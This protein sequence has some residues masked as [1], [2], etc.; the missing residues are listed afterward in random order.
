MLTSIFF[1]FEYLL[2][3]G[4][5]WHVALSNIIDN[6]ILDWE[7]NRQWNYRDALYWIFA[8]IH[9][10][11][12]FQLTPALFP[13]YHRKHQVFPDVKLTLCYASF[14]CNNRLTVADKY[15]FLRFYGLELH[16][17]TMSFRQKHSFFAPAAIFHVKPSS[18]DTDDMLCFNYREL[19][20]TLGCKDECKLLLRFNPLLGAH[21]QNCRNTEVMRQ[22][23]LNTHTPHPLTK[24]YLWVIY[25]Y[26]W[27]ILQVFISQHG[28]LNATLQ[29]GIK[30]WTL[31]QSIILCSEGRQI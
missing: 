19:Y 4:Q 1:F 25:I 18:S 8:D 22:S 31:N 9:H 6:I 23:S 26:N 3:G 11:D 27:L 17:I 13:S 20:R 30:L 7:W 16:L 28:A 15:Y 10:A 5:F 21:A 24:C 14:Y 29:P 12:V 2:T